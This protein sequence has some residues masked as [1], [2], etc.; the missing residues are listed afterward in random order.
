M[1]PD[2]FGSLIGIFIRYLREERNYSVH[3]IRSYELDLEQFNSFLEELLETKSVELHQIE[4]GMFRAY[5]GRLVRRG[6]SPR[7]IGRKIASI[8]AFFRFLT[9]KQYIESNPT[10]GL[11]APKTGRRL[12]K[13]L[14]IDMIIKALGL[15]DSNTELGLRDRAI[16]EVFYNTGIR[17]SELARLN[18]NDVDFNNATI[19]VMGKGSKERIVPFSPSAGEWLRRY[20]QLCQAK[21]HTKD[22]YSKAVFLN[23]KGQ[24][25]SPR[26][27]E[28]RVAKYLSKVS[29][30]G[31]SYPHTLRHSFAT[32][33][34][35]SGADLLT[36]K[37]LLG[38]TSL[39][40]TQ[41]YTHV[42]ADYLKRVYKQAHPRAEKEDLINKK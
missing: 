36:V 7:T 2:N 10:T 27:I 41:V 22:I 16:L 3:T 18:V 5:L 24:R 20:I 15:P 17:L 4:R 30:S 9:T 29:E 19:R 13:N 32:H 11:R 25:L 37:E 12:P 39:S 8:R 23:R 28:H 34:L 31:A 33:L 1:N 42:S 21:S 26:Q 35:D 40:T 14:S 38:H 6:H